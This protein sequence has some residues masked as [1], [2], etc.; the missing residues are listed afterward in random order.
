M[1]KTKDAF[2]LRDFDGERIL[3]RPFFKGFHF[4]ADKSDA[5]IL[6]DLSYGHDNAIIID[7]NIVIK[8]YEKKL[9]TVEDLLTRV[10]DYQKHIKRHGDRLTRYA[11]AIANKLATDDTA[12]II[13]LRASHKRA[14]DLLVKYCGQMILSY[15]IVNITDVTGVIEFV[16]ELR[17]KIAPQFKELDEM[18]KHVYRKNFADRLR[19]ARQATGLS[20]KAFAPKIGMSQNGYSYFETAQR[21]P[22]IPTLIRLSK[23]FNRSTDWLLGQTAW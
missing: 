18:V 10:A 15:G 20:Q 13:S 1:P 19:F 22:S 21:D 4:D 8:E 5:E 2:A 12:D 9:N 17:N 16:E 3:Q 14:N 7:G 6:Q 23:I 11:Q